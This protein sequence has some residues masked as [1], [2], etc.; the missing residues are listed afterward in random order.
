MPRM[1]LQGSKKDDMIV[2]KIS[3]FPVKDPSTLAL[4]LGEWWDREKW[5]IECLTV[6]GK[7]VGIDMCRVDNKRQVCTVTD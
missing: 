7:E 2:K 5:T 4:T 6:T 3:L 1:R